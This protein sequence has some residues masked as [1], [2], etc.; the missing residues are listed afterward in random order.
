MLF[1]TT[2]NYDQLGTLIKNKSVSLDNDS[3]IFGQSFES[4]CRYVKD[5]LGF[6]R[7]SRI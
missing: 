6:E 1:V 2:V 3:L 4:I 5:R 7:R